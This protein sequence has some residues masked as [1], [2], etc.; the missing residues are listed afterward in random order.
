MQQMNDIHSAASDG[1]FF[2]TV[3]I[4]CWQLGHVSSLKWFT[5]SN[6]KY[7]KNDSS[8]YYLWKLAIL[9]LYRLHR[10]VV[11]VILDDDGLLLLLAGLNPHGC[12]LTRMGYH[13]CH[14][15]GNYDPIL[16]HSSG[17]CCHNST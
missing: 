1:F 2:I 12:D 10:V 3:L 8:F 5:M 16:R 15:R 17:G 9:L 13:W 4:F 11:R 7:H 14:P 6:S